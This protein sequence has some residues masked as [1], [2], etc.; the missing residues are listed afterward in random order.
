[1]DNAQINFLAVFVASVAG[2]LFGA[3]WYSPIL[4][5]KN[6]MR[7]CGLT[8]E[9]LKKSNMS[10]IYGSAFVLQLMMALCLAPFLGASLDTATSVFYSALTVLG[11]IAPA[12]GILYLFER[13]SMKLFFINSGYL[14]FN[15][16]LMGL[17]LGLWK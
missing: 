9:E 17:I 2:F 13:R 5:Y 14:F 8:E 4:F 12:I 10:L 15:F 7:E 6:W 1:M 3:L 16:V 11:W